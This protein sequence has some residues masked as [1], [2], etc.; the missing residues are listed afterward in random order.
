M[1]LGPLRRKVEGHLRVVVGYHLAAGNVDDGGHGDA[2]RVAGEASLESVLEPGDSQHRVDTTWIQVESPTAFIVVGPAMAM[3]RTG[4]RPSR[5]RTMMARLAQ[6]QALA[7]T[8]RYR[9]G[10]TGQPSPPSA[11]TRSSM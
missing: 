9:P 8:S 3:D 11:V 6:G 10:S 5:R 2:L 1:V 4:S 7:T